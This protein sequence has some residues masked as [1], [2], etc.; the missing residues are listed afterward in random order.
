MPAPDIV[1]A[2]IEQCGRGQGPTLNGVAAHAQPLGR[3]LTAQTARQ[4]FA[5]SFAQGEHASASQCTIAEATHVN[6]FQ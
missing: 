1:R 2:G 3:A 4:S 5:Q 6:T